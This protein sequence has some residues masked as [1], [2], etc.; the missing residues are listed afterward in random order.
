MKI[1]SNLK[2]LSLSRETVR[3]LNPD[4]LRRAAGG[5]IRGSISCIS[6]TPTLCPLGRRP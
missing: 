2:K 5:A 3:N 1:A 4:E 6:L